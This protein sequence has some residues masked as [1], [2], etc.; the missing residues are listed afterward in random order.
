MI[1][2]GFCNLLSFGWQLRACYLLI[3]ISEA[4]FLL[5]YIYVV[6]LIFKAAF[7]ELRGS[8]VVHTC[9]QAFIV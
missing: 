8:R 9:S 6:A 7:R 5:H 1:K 2:L 4:I 3:D